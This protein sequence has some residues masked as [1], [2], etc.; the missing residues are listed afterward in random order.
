MKLST[1]IFNAL[2]QSIISKLKEYFMKQI[3]GNSSMEEPIE[4]QNAATFIKQLQKIDCTKMNTSPPDLEE[5]C[6]NLKNGEEAI[7][8]PTT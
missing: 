8:T 5:L 7:D 6:W 1:D 4:L 2:L 3:S